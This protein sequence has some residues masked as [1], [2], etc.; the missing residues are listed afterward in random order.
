MKI[1]TAISA[2]ILI[3]T[4]FGSANAAEIDGR[5]IRKCG[6]DT[7][8]RILIEKEGRATYK[9]T[10]ALT[11][12]PKSPLSNTSPS[13]CEWTASLRPKGDRLIGDGKFSARLERDTLVLVNAPDVCGHTKSPATFQRDDV[14]E[15][16]DI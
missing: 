14:D 16:G 11:S 2:A 12:P 1:K 8:C 5:W 10:F 13:G 4:A 15:F 3:G 6:S 7:Y 9:M